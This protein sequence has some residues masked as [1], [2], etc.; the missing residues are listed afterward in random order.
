MLT[1]TPIKLYAGSHTIGRSHCV[2][3]RDRL[4]NFSTEMMQDP[5]LHPLYAELLKQACPANLQGTATVNQ[6]LAVFMN[7]SPYITE[8]SYY[9]NLLKHEGLFTSDQALLDSQ[10]TA[11]QAAI[12]AAN[13]LGW[14]QDFAQAMIKLSQVQLLTGDQGEIRANCRLINP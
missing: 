13:D 8:S 9:V 14:K 4:Y 5:K 11:Q 10:E 6:S 12:Y 2:S 3:F 7:Q 1:R